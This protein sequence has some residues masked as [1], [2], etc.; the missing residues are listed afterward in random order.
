M[1]LNFWCRDGGKSS[2]LKRWIR[3][4]NVLLLDK[5]RIHQV[6]IF[7]WS[8]FV[9]VFHF[10]ILICVRSFRYS[11]VSK[12]FLFKIFS[13]SSILHTNHFARTLLNSMPSKTYGFFSIILYM[14][15][16]FVKGRVLSCNFNG[17]YHIII[18][19]KLWYW[20]ARIFNWIYLIQSHA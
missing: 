1:R 11:T 14:K 6:S 17:I 20:F 2:K 8:C 19:P 18:R 5:L 3:I 9:V 10:H 4:L 12:Q 7:Q 13:T 15:M 16:P